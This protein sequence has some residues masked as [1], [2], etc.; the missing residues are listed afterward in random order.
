MEKVIRVGVLNN[1]NFSKKE[2]DALLPYTVQGKVMVNGNAYNSIDNTY[3][4]FVTAN[5]NLVTV[6]LHGDLSNVK[7][8]RVKVWLN[9]G[10]LHKNC[11]HTLQYVSSLRIPVLLTF[12]HFKSLK[13]LTKYSSRQGYI[14]NASYFRPTK[15]TQNTIVEQSKQYIPS[16]LLYSCDAHGNG[17]ISCMNCSFLSYGI[18]N[19]ELK[20]LNLSISGKKDKRGKQGL[21]KYNCVDC[22]AK[23]VTCGSSPKCN[24]LFSN[25][26]Q[27]GNVNHI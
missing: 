13:T 17:C 4:S 25:R 11:V 14:W 5:P 20:G 9:N 1:F 12:M 24:K 19:A 7:A 27:K 10:K 18:Q 23:K 22:F 16:N 26:K 6:Y 21:C 3:P 2:I 15:E 8:V